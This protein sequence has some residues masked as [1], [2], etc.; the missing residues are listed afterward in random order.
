MIVFVGGAAFQVTEIG[1]REWAISLA[2][3]FVSIPLG[4]LI[5]CI[6]NEPAERFFKAVHL[7]PKEQI[8][9]I[10]RPDAEPGLGFALDRVQDNLG[11]F[12]KLRGGRIRSSSF[13]VKSRSRSARPDEPKVV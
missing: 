3:G 7:L 8:L 4:A 1:G 2:L 9:P 13:V 5:R 6:P 12:S 10:R 11:T